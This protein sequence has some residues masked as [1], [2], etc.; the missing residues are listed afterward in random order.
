MCG[1]KTGINEFKLCHDHESN[2]PWNNFTYPPS[3][4]P[5]GG[6]LPPPWPSTVLETMTSNAANLIKY[7]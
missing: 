4:P 2:M 3:G 5:T 6:L 1:L 7:F